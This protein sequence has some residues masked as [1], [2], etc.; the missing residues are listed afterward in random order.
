MDARFVWDSTGCDSRYGIAEHVFHSSSMPNKVYETA[1]SFFPCLLMPGPWMPRLQW[2][3]GDRAAREPAAQ[4]PRL[5]MRPT[6]TKA[7]VE[8]GELVKVWWPCDA[9]PAQFGPV[10]TARSFARL[11]EEGDK[12]GIIFKMRHAP[13]RGSINTKTPAQLETDLTQ[14]YL[15]QIAGP[16][17]TTRDFYEDVRKLMATKR[18][19][20]A[21][22]P[23]PRKLTVLTVT[24][25]VVQKEMPAVGSAGSA[26]ATGKEY[27]ADDIADDTDEGEPPCDE[28]LVFNTM[29]NLSTGG[30][31]VSPMEVPVAEDDV[32]YPNQSA[33][34]DDPA[35]WEFQILLDEAVRLLE[36]FR[37]HGA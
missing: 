5:D 1:E 18:Q 4:K 6:A 3:G 36:V 9:A 8:N 35:H 27:I 30:R 20:W 23:H 21:G 11:K 17:G 29:E 14:P 13:R 25:W 26:T 24:G 12:Q 7:E 16:L 10:G 2:L 22:L 15:V 28:D 37:M 32:Q 34:R 31:L 19:N 33:E